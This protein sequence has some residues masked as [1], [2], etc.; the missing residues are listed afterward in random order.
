MA[1]P[2]VP[3]GTEPGAGQRG[4]GEGGYGQQLDPEG[5]ARH[6]RQGV[7]WGQQVEAFGTLHPRDGSGL[8]RGNDGRMSAELE[9]FR[10]AGSAC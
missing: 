8:G 4:C 2:S 3:R 9:K 5:L 10:E 1:G 6:R 7:W